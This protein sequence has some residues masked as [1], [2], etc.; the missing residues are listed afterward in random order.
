MDW[1]LG[2]V[3]KISPNLK[4]WSLEMMRCQFSFCTCP[5]CHTGGHKCS[6]PGSSGS[7]NGDSWF[8]SRHPGL[9]HWGRRTQLPAKLFSSCVNIRGHVFVLTLR[10]A[11]SVSSIW[12]ALNGWTNSFM[13]RTPISLTTVSW[14]LH[15][16]KNGPYPSSEI[17]GA[18]SPCRLPSLWCPE[19]WSCHCQEGGCPADS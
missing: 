9:S 19:E 15:L 11:N 3:N 13:T 7:G 12:I 14:G 16:A 5:L 10:Q 1:R 17:P 8:D 18:Q 6:L 2:S 4:K